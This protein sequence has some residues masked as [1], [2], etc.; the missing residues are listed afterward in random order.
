MMRRLLTITIGGLLTVALFAG[1][2][3]AW[4]YNRSAY[5][6]DQQ[7]VQFWGDV[8]FPGGNSSANDGELNDPNRD[9][10]SVLVKTRHWFCFMGCQL[11]ATDLDDGVMDEQV[12]FDHSNTSTNEVTTWACAQMGWPVPDAC[13]TT[14]K[15]PD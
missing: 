8:T 9:G 13:T 6:D 7:R 15:E 1:S 11:W 2:V 3:S 12:S 4:D 5:Y 10:N 14:Y